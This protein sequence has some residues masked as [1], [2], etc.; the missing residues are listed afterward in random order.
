LVA[1]AS[2][3]RLAIHLQQFVGAQQCCAPTCPGQRIPSPCSSRA[4][5]L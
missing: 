1:E 2:Q 3:F 4:D 5:Y